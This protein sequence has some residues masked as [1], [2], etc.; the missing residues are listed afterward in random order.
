M[1]DHALTFCG[2]TSRRLL[3]GSCVAL[4]LGGAAQQASATVLT[5]ANS[6]QPGNSENAGFGSNVNQLYGDNVTGTNTSAAGPT[7]S[8]GSAGGFTP[9]VTVAYSSGGTPGDELVYLNDGQGY[10]QGAGALPAALYENVQN[11]GGSLTVTFTAAPGFEVTLTSLDLAGYDV[12]YTLNSFEVTG[13]A[14][15]FSA[16]GQPVGFPNKT[17]VNI[18]RTGSVLTLSY[19]RS[20]TF[21]NI[22][23]SNVQFS[24]S[25]IPEPASLGLIALGGLG[26]LARRR[27]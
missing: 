11:D 3:A 19:A 15:P 10:G 16:P 27:R 2:N 1:R 20:D 22:G 23:L 12:P 13:G 14:T 5:F 6:A 9:N 4:L 25:A 17:T 8:Y 7:F 26:V 21:S 24:Q 18:D